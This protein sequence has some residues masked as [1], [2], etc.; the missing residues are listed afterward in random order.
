MGRPKKDPSLCRV[1]ITASVAPELSKDS[2]A[3]K[4]Y[5]ENPGNFIK[6]E[7]PTYNNCVEMG[8]RKV[9]NVPEIKEE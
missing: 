4:T 1:H 5:R 2:E 3:F 6:N 7:K 9:F 8:L